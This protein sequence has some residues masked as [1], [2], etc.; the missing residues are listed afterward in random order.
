M[1]DAAASDG[2]TPTLFPPP[3]MLADASTC[4]S[5]HAPL[6]PLMLTKPR[7]PTAYASVGEIGKTSFKWPLTGLVIDDFQLRVSQRELGG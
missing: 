2:T 4:V 3:E 6:V 7:P 1:E 5:K